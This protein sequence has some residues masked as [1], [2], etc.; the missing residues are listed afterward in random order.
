MKRLRAD[1][2]KWY[3]TM[4]MNEEQTR[5]IA[6]FVQTNHHEKNVTT[7]NAVDILLKLARD[8][9]IPELFIKEIED[10]IQGDNNASKIARAISLNLRHGVMIK[11]VVRA[12]DT[13]EDVYVGSFLFVIRKYLSTFIRDGETVDGAKCD[14][15][16]GKVVYQEGCYKCV[17]CGSSKCG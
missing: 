7:S 13:M 6:F 14:E 17:N 11:N 2:K 3:V 16:G 1:G 9:G 5:P 12:L 4:I 8:K 15:C 10:K